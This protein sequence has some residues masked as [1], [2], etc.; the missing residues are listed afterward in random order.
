MKFVVPLIKLIIC[1]SLIYYLVH[2]KSLDFKVLEILIHNKTVLVSTVF[3]WLISAVFLVSMRWRILLTS[4]GTQFKYS[5]ILRLNL[6]GLMFNSFI[7]GLV[8]GDVLKS[9]YLRKIYPSISLRWAI[10]SS[11]LDRFIGL[12]SLFFIAAFSLVLK[13][14]LMQ[15]KLQVIIGIFLIVFLSLTLVL[16]V[17]IFLSS[18]H[19]NRMIKKYKS[20]WLIDKMLPIIQNFPRKSVVLKASLLGI[21]SQFINLS[22]IVL[23]TETL[24]QKSS[25]WLELSIIFPLGMLI[26]TLPI[27]PGGLGVGH[28]AFS[29][30][31]E[32]IGIAQG[33]NIFN[34][35]AVSQMSLNLLGAIPFVFLKR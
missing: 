10:A 14:T 11:L 3:V 29:N 24:T 16:F 5:D 9:H 20:F 25:S 19:A 6:I 27:T 32:M 12:Y 17:L 8:S 15:T 21:C 1:G 7:P 18:G 28:I 22:F 31:F 23:L 30:L 34:L 2:N 26:T 33:A 4:S 35:F 13:P